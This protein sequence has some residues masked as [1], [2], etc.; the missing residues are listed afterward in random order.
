MRTEH[1]TAIQPGLQRQGRI[2]GIVARQSSPEPSERLHT[3]GGRGHERRW[4]MI[5]AGYPK[6]SLSREYNLF[7]MSRQPA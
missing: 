5:Q 1:T 3:A 6:V 4:A 2:E 7:R